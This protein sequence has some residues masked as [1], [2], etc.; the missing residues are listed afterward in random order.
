MGLSIH[1]LPYIFQSSGYGIWILNENKKEIAYIY[2][3]TAFIHKIIYTYY[4]IFRS[5][6]EKKK[7]HQQ[8]HIVTTIYLQVNIFLDTFPHIVW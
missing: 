6:M 5:I 8:K 4:K 7:T 1:T 2:L 3:M